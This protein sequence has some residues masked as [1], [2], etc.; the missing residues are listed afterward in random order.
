M[1]GDDGVPDLLI[2]SGDLEVPVAFKALGDPDA[3]LH[4]GLG[5]EIRVAEG[6]V[7][8]FKNADCKKQAQQVSQTAKRVGNGAKTCTKTCKKC[9]KKCD[10]SDS[11][12]KKKRRACKI[13]RVNCLRGCAESTAN[14]FNAHGEEAAEAAEAAAEAEATDDGDDWDDDEE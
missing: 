5:E 12:C 9:G 7:G 2:K 14:S 1:G 6:L 3:R 10:R 4:G 8:L 13:K 11:A